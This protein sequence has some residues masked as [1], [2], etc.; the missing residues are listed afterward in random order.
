MLV[1]SLATPSFGRVNGDVI[2]RHICTSQILA[3]FELLDRAR[4][5]FGETAGKLLSHSVTVDLTHS[6]T[7]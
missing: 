4:S 5:C 3:T 1:P 6:I 7:P 2:L